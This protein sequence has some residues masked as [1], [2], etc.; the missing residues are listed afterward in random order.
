M[1]GQID[2]LRTPSMEYGFVIDNQRCTGCHACTVACKAEHQVALGDFRTWVKNVEKGA[3]PEVR[4]HF[5]VLRCNHC[6]DAPCVTICPT[7]ALFHRR[8]G[9]VDF[10][11]AH[12]IG[13]R[14]CMAAC[15]Y[16]AIYIDPDSRTAAK[17]NF[18]AHKIEIGIE[19]PC[20]SIC[21]E[22]AIIAGDLSNPHSRISGI[23]AL[24]QV[25]VR[26]PEKGTHPRVFYVAG[27]AAC[28]TPEEVAHFGSGAWAGLRDGGAPPAQPHDAVQQAPR[29][30][31]DVSHETPWGFTLSLCLWAKSIA[32]GPIL[33]AALLMLMHIARAPILFGIYAPLMAIGMVFTTVLLLIGD[34]RRPGRFLKILFHPNPHSW[35]VWGANILTAFLAVALLWFLAGLAA[36]Q[37]VITT[38]L[39]PGLVLSAM[40]AGYSAF[41]L[42]Q[43]RGRDLWQSRLL[44]P[45][46]IVQAFLAGCA[47]LVM[48][49]ALFGSGRLLSEFL[50]RCLLGSLCVHGL[51]ILGELALPHGTEAGNRAAGYILHGPLSFLFWSGAV[52]AGIVIPVNVLA[53]TIANPAVGRQLGLL[54]PCLALA[55]LLSYQHAYVRAGQALPLS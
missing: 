48:G 4:R 2:S 46:L 22:G 27:D 42:A 38:L 15:P 13:C 52:L 23:V 14:A 28:L 20:V 50:A 24:S 39:W 34:L 7:R 49:S 8:D 10:D 51:L 29:V 36:L 1:V 26:K 33:V 53:Y 5:T 32:A 11:S 18:C 37:Q 40:A 25:S 43:A 16:D 3:F 54:A 47:T 41:L 44:F 21:P 9:I 17:C 55:G 30:V 6:R 35:L 19:P 45:H 12:C 31:Y